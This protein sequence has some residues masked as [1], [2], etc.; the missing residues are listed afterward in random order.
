MDVL[1]WNRFYGLMKPNVV[2][3]I[4]LKK[5]SAYALCSNSHN[6]FFIYQIWAYE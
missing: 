2:F 6:F 5:K 4:F 3:P 1:M